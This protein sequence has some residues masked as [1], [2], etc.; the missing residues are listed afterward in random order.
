MEEDFYMEQIARHFGAETFERT[1]RLRFNGLQLQQLVIFKASS[2][3]REEWINI[4][5]R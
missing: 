2:L 1:N 3:I 4:E 5:E